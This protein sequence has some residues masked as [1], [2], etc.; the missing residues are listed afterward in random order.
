MF[1]IATPNRRAL[2][3][4]VIAAGILSAGQSRAAA[5][6]AS[7]PSP[8][9]LDQLPSMHAAAPATIAHKSPAM[10]Y[11]PA[12]MQ[13]H[14][15]SRIKTLHEKLHITPAQEEKW[16]VVAQA[17][18]DNEKTISQLIRER[19]LKPE[20]M[21]AVDDLKSYE[22]IAQAHVDGLKLLTP[23]FEALYNDMSVEQ[24]SN[25]DEAFSHFEGHRGHSAMKKR[26]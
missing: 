20:N 25:A 22:K 16:D 13:Q 18:R 21:S 17:M 19:H 2:A 10:A 15:E 26:S 6:E 9:A 3:V 4:L 8:N 7:E 11:S 23:V 12:T 1:H 5:S 24:K 14:V